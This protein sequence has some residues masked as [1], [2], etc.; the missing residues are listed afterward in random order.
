MIAWDIK[1][2]L[3]RMEAEYGSEVTTTEILVRMTGVSPEEVPAVIGA[4]VD[5][6]AQITRRDYLT[7]DAAAINWVD[8]F[9]V[10]WSLS[11]RKITLE[12]PNG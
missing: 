10:G 11:R 6:S 8:G 9:M 1:A 12:E 4:A 2:E 5:R 3:V 7:L